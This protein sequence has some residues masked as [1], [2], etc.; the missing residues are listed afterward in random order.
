MHELVVAATEPM[1]ALFPLGEY[2]GQPSWRAVPRSRPPV[3][4][5]AE[6]L[7]RKAG[8]ANYGP[9]VPEARA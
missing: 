9:I 1:L 6:Q 4:R 7:G 3:A 8:R 5:P 2:T